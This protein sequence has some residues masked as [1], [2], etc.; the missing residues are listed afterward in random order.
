MGIFS[1]LS[2]VVGAGL[3]AVSKY[4]WI[5]IVLIGIAGIVGLLYFLSVARK[6]KHQWTHKIKIQRLL[7]DG[8]L[9]K[10]IVHKAR[11]FP[12]EQGVEMFEVDKPILGSYLIPQPGEYTGINEFSIILDSYNRIYLNK[13]SKF[14]KDKQSVEVSCVHAGI[15]VEMANMKDKWQQAHK[16][17]KRITTA[18]LIKA[19]LKALG[20]I[21]LVIIGIVALQQWG[22]AQQFKA[23]SDQAEADAMKHIKEAVVTMEKVVN[24]QQ[25]QIIPMLEALYGKQNIAGE[26]NKYC[27]DVGVE[28]ET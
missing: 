18:E 1:G 6:K 28:D 19:G 13:G 20:I 23:Q 9:T 24:T 12:L 10:E 16:V 11:R 7:Q 27:P 26:I 15:D 14:N 3:G 22:D 5:A 17:D 8:T 21:A 2:D 25:L 4:G